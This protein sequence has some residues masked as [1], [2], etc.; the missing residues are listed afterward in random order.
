LRSLILSTAARTVTP[1]LLVFSVFAF[2]RGH[3]EPGGGFIGGLIAATGLG[4]IALA[5]GTERMLQVLRVPPRTL[6]AMGL[7]A[8]LASTLFGLPAGDV[9]L[10]GVW[11]SV[12]TP[13]GEAK[14][15]TPL[16]FDLGVYL[17]VVGTVLTF[18]ATLA[19]EQHA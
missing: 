19:E 12:P 8:A 2:L 6:L 16:L 5:D 4:L 3:N 7:L 15:G 13:F 14:L 10:K 11:V 1:L 18:I 17:V 9:L